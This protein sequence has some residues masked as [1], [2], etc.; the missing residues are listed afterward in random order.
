MNVTEN[1]SDALSQSELFNGI[2]PEIFAEILSSGK[3]TSVKS[4]EILFSEGDRAES[5]YLVLKGRLK[6]TKLHEQGKEV[7]IRYID[8]GS[9]AAAIAVFKGKKY[10]VTATA[11]GIAE[12][13]GWDKDTLLKLISNYGQLALNLLRFT[14]DRIEELQTRYLELT[15]EQVERRIAR[16]LLRIM[17]QSGRKTVEGVEIDFQLSRQDLADYT[18]TTLYTVSR[19]LS[20]WGKKGWVKSSR[21]RITITDP[22]S[23]VNFSETD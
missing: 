6:L 7:I 21:Q 22:H 5:C 23:L 2:A 12:V 14:I 15:A 4:G 9:I 8:T 11:L 10:P 1:Y 16:A 3:K 19:T 17:R 13:I 18:G 20:T